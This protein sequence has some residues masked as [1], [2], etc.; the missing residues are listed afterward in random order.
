MYEAKA[1]GR[2]T[3]R[4]FDPGHA[5]SR[6]RP[7]QPGSRPAPGPAARRACVHYQPWWTTTATSKAP[8]PWCAGHPE[9]GMPSAPSNSSPWPNRPASSCR[10]A[11]LCCTPPANNCSAGA[12]TGHR[13]PFDRRQRQRPPI[14]P[15][16]LCWRRAANPARDRRQ[17][18]GA[19]N[20]NSPKACCWA[21]SKTPSSAWC[22]SSAKAWALRWTTLAPGTP[23]WATSSACRSTRSR[24]TRA[25]CAT[26]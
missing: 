7:L 1:A 12:G 23:A 6:A 4:F 14:S 20:S 2:N 10:W 8:K 3:H 16:R 5:A 19:S 18:H 22:S 24:S 26:C 11:N 17:P 15:T 13:P 25:S 21:T 9:R